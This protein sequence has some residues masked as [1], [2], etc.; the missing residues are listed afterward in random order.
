MNHGQLIVFAASQTKIF[1]LLIEVKFT[2]AQL[3]THCELDLWMKLG[4]G[5]AE[6]RKVAGEP[7]EED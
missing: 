5:Q 2:Y 3:E 7:I 6:H 1:E 4:D